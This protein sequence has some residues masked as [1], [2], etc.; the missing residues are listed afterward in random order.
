MTLD[1]GHVILVYEFLKNTCGTIKGHTC[2]AR[3]DFLFN[4][5]TEW[6]EFEKCLQRLVPT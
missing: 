3:K 2:P 4:R 6:S 1:E 5:T